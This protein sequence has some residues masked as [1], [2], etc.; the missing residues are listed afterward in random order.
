MTLQRFNA[1]CDYY[2]V[3][4]ITPEEIEAAKQAPFQTI[5]RPAIGV[6]NTVKMRGKSWRQL[7]ESRDTK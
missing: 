1:W 5:T 6:F 4:R 3:A 2:H 7:G